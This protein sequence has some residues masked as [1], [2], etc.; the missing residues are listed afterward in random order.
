M[1]T[2][3]SDRVVLLESAL[4]RT[5]VALWISV[6][7]LGTLLVPTLGMAVYAVAAFEGTAGSAHVE[8]GSSANATSVLRAAQLDI[9]DSENN[10]VLSL[11]ADARGGALEIRSSTGIP[12]IEARCVGLDGNVG[13]GGMIA[14]HE[15]G[16]ERRVFIHSG[17]GGAGLQVRRDEDRSVV[18]IGDRLGYGFVEIQDEPGRDLVALGEVPLVSELLAESNPEEQRSL[19]RLFGRSVSGGILVPSL[20]MGMDKFG[21]YVH[22]FDPEGTRAAAMGGGEHGGRVSLSQVGGE[23]VVG[24][25]ASEIGGVLGLRN[26]AGKDVLVAGSGRDGDGQLFVF[27]RTGSHRITAGA[28]PDV[29]GVVVYNTRGVNVCQVVAMPNGNGFVAVSSADAKA[30]KSLRPE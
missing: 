18:G 7:I 24:I 16:L 14:L 17:L 15:P 1:D 8:D 13:L 12:V 30:A 6:S 20:N 21:G 4:H 23:T 27:D 10:V 9:I 26:P 2:Q 5:R 25:G 28:T 22:A 29:G 3:L 11:G 19:V